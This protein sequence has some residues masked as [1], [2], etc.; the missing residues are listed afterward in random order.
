MV[1]VYLALTFHTGILTWTQSSPFWPCKSGRLNPRVPEALSVGVVIRIPSISSLDTVISDHPRTSWLKL[2]LVLHAWVEILHQALEEKSKVLQKKL[3]I[4]KKRWKHLFK[5]HQ[6]S[7]KTVF[8]K[9]CFI[10]GDW[11]SWSLTGERRDKRNRK[12]GEMDRNKLMF[13]LS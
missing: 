6:L 3:H 11:G 7:L 8:E 13:A 2:Q 10:F 9:P 12:T 4:K 1:D 5:K